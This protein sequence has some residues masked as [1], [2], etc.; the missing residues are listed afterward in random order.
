M[1][2]N[3]MLVIIMQVLFAKFGMFFE[4]ISFVA[5]VKCDSSPNL[6][7]NHMK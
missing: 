6:Q 5:G 7:N 3:L 2:C 4:I 1:G